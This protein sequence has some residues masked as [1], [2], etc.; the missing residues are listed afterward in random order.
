MDERTEQNSAPLEEPFDYNTLDETIRIRVQTNEEAIRA[1][2]KR[3]AEEII[4]MGQRLIQVKQD[5]GHGLFLKWLKTQFDMSESLATKFMQVAHRFGDEIK[6]VKITNLPATVLY[7]LAAPSTPDEVVQRVL[8]GEIPA[9]AQAIKEAKEALQS[10]EDQLHQEQTKRSIAETALLNRNYETQ[11]TLEE[12]RK[13]KQERD[14]LKQH[15][16][17]GQEAYLEKIHQLKTSNTFLALIN[18]GTQRL[19]EIKFYMTHLISNSGMIREIRRLGGEHQ[20]D[21]VIFLAQ[22][23]STYETL[24]EVEIKLTTEGEKEGGVVE[25]EPQSHPSPWP[26]DG[27]T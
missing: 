18:G 23:Q 17:F 26:A 4:D 2:I 15:L 6:S 9:N 8:T 12:L 11:T 5:L 3:T 22:L 13:V 21:F 14:E 16:E 25:S 7:S 1:S 19:S 27:N 10:T 24:R 20:R